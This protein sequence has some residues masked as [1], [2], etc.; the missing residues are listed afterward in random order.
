M[1]NLDC[2]TGSARPWHHAF[3]AWYDHR[4]AGH[5]WRAAFYGWLADRLVR[6]A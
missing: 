1:H 4:E 6:W 2:C 3:A 5:R